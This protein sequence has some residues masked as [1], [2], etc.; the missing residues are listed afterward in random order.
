MTL[1]LLVAVFFAC[2][3]SANHY[4]AFLTRESWLRQVVILGKSLGGKGGK[5]LT[6][7]LE[8]MKAWSA[9]DDDLIW[10]RRSLGIHA[11]EADIE[12]LPAEMVK[13]YQDT[14]YAKVRGC[15]RLSLVRF[16]PNRDGGPACCELQLF[17]LCDVRP[18]I[19]AA[20]KLNSDCMGADHYRE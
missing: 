4:G 5:S 12:Y 11:K 1:D 15:P 3:C 19:V 17:L 20:L 16:P 10:L 9:T 13:A 2:G 18:T 6:A 8:L 14:H 7:M